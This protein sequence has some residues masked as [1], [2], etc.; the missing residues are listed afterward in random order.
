MPVEVIDMWN[1]YRTTPRRLPDIGQR[2]AYMVGGGI[3]S[4]SAAV[5]L[6]EDARMPGENIY[7]IEKTG[8]VGGSLDGAGD[9]ERGYITRGGR[10]FEPMYEATWDLFA[11]IP[12]L[13]N[14][15]ITLLDE[16]VAF[17]REYVGS[18][19][20]RL[21]GTPGKKL[22]FSRYGLNFRHINQ[23]TE[24]MLTPEEDLSYITIQQWFDP[25]FFKTNFWY[26]WATMFAFQP[27]HSVAEM[28]RYMIRFIHHVPG[29][30]RIEG[31]LRTPY[32]QYDSV[33]LPIRRW[34]EARGVNFVMGTKVL[35]V[36]IEQ[37][38]DGRKYV[39]ALVVQ[40]GAEVERIPVTRKDLV[41]ITNGSMVENSAYGD[42]DSPAPLIRTEGDVW[43][44]WR[45]LVKKDPAFGNPDVFASDIDKTKWES[46]TVT[47]RGR[48]FIDML[49]KFTGNRTGT[50]GLVTFRDSSW[51]MSIVAFRQPH[52]RNQPE[53][54]TVIWG[55]GLFVDKEGDYVKKP[56]AEATGR[57]MLLEVLYHLGWLDYKDEIMGEVVNVIPAMMPYI[58]SQFMPRAIGDRP[59]IV[60]EGYDNLA[61]LG[62]FAELENEC[63]FT[64]E[65]SVKSAMVAVYSLLPLGKVPPETYK[66]QYDIRV[67]M[68]AAQSL[69]DPEL[70]Q[71]LKG[72]IMKFL[73]M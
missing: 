61:F 70:Q 62:Q 8:M 66:G 41:F 42:L 52:F 60:P 69:L 45:N 49:E 67:L 16:V 58:T 4:L 25:S 39:S 47:F 63:V 35:D 14:P 21:V 59:P 13:D 54:V 38:E 72:Y 40:R 43:R 9:P 2:K 46:F 55:Y 31:I 32:N 3:A 15:E 6:I 18:S 48:K 10:M 53:D 24:L 36:E 1:I 65:Y 26:F 50:G 20:C 33:I 22:D 27:W 30:K 64:V 44:L 19:K 7:I 73:S 12:S 11:R 37:A 28:R 68:R 51:L 17:N 56:M 29:L 5:F 23:M 71:R 57:E 34:L